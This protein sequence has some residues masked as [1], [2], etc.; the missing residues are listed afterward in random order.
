MEKSNLKIGTVTQT[1]SYKL[2]GRAGS[3]T[4]RGTSSVTINGMTLDPQESFE[5]PYSTAPYD[6][7]L[8]INFNDSGSKK[9]VIIECVV[10]DKTSC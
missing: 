7:T 6:Q 8:E 3:I 9:L 1:G 10:T 4:N 5:I 2:T